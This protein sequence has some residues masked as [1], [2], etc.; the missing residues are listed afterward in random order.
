M[1][2]TKFFEK[3]PFIVAQIPNFSLAMDDIV[4]C[5]GKI[6]EISLKVLR[7]VNKNGGMLL[8]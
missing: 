4:L 6:F 7:K 3:A 5:L 2:K 8:K 1:L